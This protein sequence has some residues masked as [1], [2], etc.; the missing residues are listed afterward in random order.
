MELSILIPAKNEEFLAKTIENILE[1]IEADTEIIAVLDGYWH[2]IKQHPRVT[3]VH[4]EESVGQRAG[5]NLACR[6]AKGKYVMKV[7]AHC[8]FDKGFDRKMLELFAKE[9]DNVTAVPVMRNLHAFDWKC[10]ACGN[11]RYQ[12]RSGVCDKCGGETV[13]DIKWIGKSNPQSTSYCFDSEPHFQYFN[14]WKKNQV[15]D[16]VETMSLQ[17]SCFMLSKEM[18]W[19]LNICDESFGS[20]GSQGIEVA[21]KTWLSG[22]RVLVNKNTWYAHMFRTQG[23]DFGFPYHLSGKDVQHAKDMARKLILCDFPHKIRN[24]SWLLEKFH[25]VKGWSDKDIAELKAKEKTQKGIIFYTDNQLNLKIAHK[26][27][28]RLR[29]IGLPIVSTSL[30]QMTFGHN[31]VVKGERG[32]DTYYKQIITALEN[33]QAEIVYFCE[34]D[35]LYNKSHF[36][37]IPPEKDKFYYNLNVWKVSWETGKAMKVD[38]CEQVSGLVCYRETALAYYRKKRKDAHYEPTPKQHFYSTEPLYDIRHDKNMTKSK[39]SIEDFKNKKH[40]KG[41]QFDTIKI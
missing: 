32:M 27:Q 20:W 24:T 5:T 19:K 38:V 28:N 2:E 26:V 3:V 13:K 6:L 16:Y 1:N 36:E 22:G 37:F 39:W 4:L 30:K 12:G 21:L 15:G 8:S 11:S 7:D 34:H 10:T 14:E 29:N 17:G 41:L 31:I 18:Y 23:G 25:P 33:S 35:V 9:G 40:A